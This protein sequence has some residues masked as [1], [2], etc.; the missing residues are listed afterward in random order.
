MRRSARANLIEIRKARMARKSAISAD[1]NRL[2]ASFEEEQTSQSDPTPQDAIVTAAAEPVE[3]DLVADEAMSTAIEDDVPAEEAGDIP[4]MDS[5]DELAT[6][7]AAMPEMETPEIETPIA[8][9]E[10]VPQAEPTE[11]DVA[12]KSLIEN[13]K[14]S[15]L[16][17]LPG[18]GPGLIWMLAQCDI[19]SL[20]TLATQDATELAARLGVVGQILDVGQWITFAQEYG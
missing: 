20:A 8:P 11:A 6:K 13:W 1:N 2:V 4:E 18:A 3:T 10:T 17:A 16:A 19:D 9:V 7:N 12:P 5:L 14:E 15:D